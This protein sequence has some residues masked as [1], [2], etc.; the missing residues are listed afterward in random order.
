[1]NRTGKVALWLVAAHAAVLVTAYLGT[2][3]LADHNPSGQCEGIGFGCSPTPRDGARILLVVAG[4]PAVTV[5]LLLSLVVTSIVAAARARR[6][7]KNAPGSLRG[8]F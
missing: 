7:N 4:L 3:A 6:A 8:R 2:F 1:M 5:S